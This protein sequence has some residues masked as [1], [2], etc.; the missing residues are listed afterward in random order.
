MLFLQLKTF[1][2]NIESWLSTILT[3]KAPF[4]WRPAYF[5]T[6]STPYLK[7]CPPPQI[8]APLSLRD[9]N[10][11]KLKSTLHEDASKQV[12]AFL[13]DWF[14]TRGVLKKLKLFFQ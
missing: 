4:L 12:S 1:G 10:L 5:F 6:H 13:D 2:K 3:L 9:L 14:L 11:N 8:V 7:I